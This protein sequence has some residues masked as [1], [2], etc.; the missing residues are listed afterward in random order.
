MTCQTIPFGL[1]NGKLRRADARS[2]GNEGKKR[3]KMNRIR[4]ITL[5][6]FVLQVYSCSDDSVTPRPPQQY[7]DWLSQG[8]ESL[9]DASFTDANTGTVVGGG[10][11]I[12]RTTDGGTTWVRQ[13]SGTA[14]RLTGVSFTDASTGTVVGE[15]GTILRTTD[16]GA[17]WMSQTSGTTHYLA[18]VS[19]T[20]ANTGTVV[21]FDGTILRTTKCL[22]ISAE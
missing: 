20:D 11:T 9:Y 12:L 16:G 7:C 14:N 5:L 21:G 13:K 10:G 22:T 3:R 8:S 15:E 2:S 6:A 4:L 17:T 18:G 1:V 19:F